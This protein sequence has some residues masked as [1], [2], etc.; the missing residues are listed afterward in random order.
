MS[1]E[2]E[3][4]LSQHSTATLYEEQMPPEPA[5]VYLLIKEKN[6]S[7]PERDKSYGVSYMYIML[8]LCSNHWA[9]QN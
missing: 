4:E 9:L 6:E 8:C 3:V 7:P 2:E 5:K 1:G